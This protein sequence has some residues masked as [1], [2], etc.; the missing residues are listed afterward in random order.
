MDLSGSI[1][2]VGFGEVVGK[3]VVAGIGSDVGG[4]GILNERGS[5]RDHAVRRN[6]DALVVT[7]EEIERFDDQIELIALVEPQCPGEAGVGSGVVGSGKSIAAVAGETIVEAIRV[8]VRIAGDGCVEGPSATV[9]DYARNFPV[10]EDVAEQFVAAMK[11]VRCSG[12]C[13]DETLALVSYAG[14]ALGAGHVRILDGGRLPGDESILAVI[15]GM[16]VGVRESKVRAASYSPVQGERSSVVIAG[17]GALEFVDG[18]EL[19]DG[20][21]ERIDAGREGAGQ[22]ARELPGGKGV[23]GVVSAIED[24]AGGVEDRIGQRAGLR[25]INIQ[26]ANQVFAMNREQRE[27]YGATVRDLFFQREISL[28]YARGHEVWCEGGNMVGDT[29]GES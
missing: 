12:E 13:C 5:A 16:S 7:V 23:H 4:D 14:S 10:I 17:G 27:S 15:D 29:L 11:R 6:G 21:S 20:T 24:G 1:G 25:K 8:L 26:R 22:G 18:A 19:R 2:G 28:L 3:R 9:V